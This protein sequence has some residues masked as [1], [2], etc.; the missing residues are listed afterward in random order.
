MQAAVWSSLKCFWRI[1]GPEQELEGKNGFRQRHRRHEG[2]STHNVTRLALS[3]FL[4]V[5]QK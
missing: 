4:R 1:L 5:F 3:P 2:H